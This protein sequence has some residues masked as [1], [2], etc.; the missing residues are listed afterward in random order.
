MSIYHNYKTFG[1]FEK[2]YSHSILALEYNEAYEKYG[3]NF[4]KISE[5][6]KILLKKNALKIRIKKMIYYIK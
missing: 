4:S 2:F 5:F 3:L 6:Q 1:T